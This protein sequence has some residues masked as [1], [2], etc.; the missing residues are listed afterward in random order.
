MR[1]LETS[2]SHIY[3]HLIDTTLDNIQKKIVYA[4][5]LLEDA[6]LVQLIGVGC[7]YILPMDK[8]RERLAV[9]TEI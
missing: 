5:I 4:N 3:G 2:I 7:D 1:F 8:V 9:T 6:S